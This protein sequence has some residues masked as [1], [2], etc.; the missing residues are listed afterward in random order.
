MIGKQKK[1]RRKHITFSRKNW[2]CQARKR[3]GMEGGQKVR[4]WTIGGRHRGRDKKGCHKRI[5][6]DSMVTGG[7]GKLSVLHTAFDLDESIL[8]SFL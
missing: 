7:R 8:M 1:N 4:E 2:D 6:G 3:Q 5:W